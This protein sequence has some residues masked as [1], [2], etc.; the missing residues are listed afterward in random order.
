MGNVVGLANYIVLVSRDAKRTAIH[1]SAAPIRYADGSLSGVVLVFRDVATLAL[2]FE[3]TIRQTTKF[4]P[5]GQ[6]ERSLTNIN[7]ADAGL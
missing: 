1:D 7:C 6:C 2:V 5:A 3:L 4:G